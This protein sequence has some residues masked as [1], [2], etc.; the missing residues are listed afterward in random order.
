L[1]GNWRRVEG[2]WTRT[3]FRRCG[4]M[5]GVFDGLGLMV[6]GLGFRVQALEVSSTRSLSTRTR[7]R[8]LVSVLKV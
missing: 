1:D 2:L 8:F 4:L 7:I 5:L 6:Q 3:R